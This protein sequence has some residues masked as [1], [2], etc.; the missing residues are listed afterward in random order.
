MASRRERRAAQKA[1]QLPLRERLASHER[2]GTVLRGPSIAVKCACGERR[3]LAYGEVWNCTCGRRWNTAQI[4][5]PEYQRLHRLQLRF[6]ILPVCLGVGVSLLALFFIVSHNTFSLFVLLPA[7]LILW[8][9]LLRPAHRRRYAAAMGEL[10]R[11]SLVP[12]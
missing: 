5:A 11:W 8:S 9:V 1:A 4:P 2:P 6:R 7:A 10:P 12:E 3:D